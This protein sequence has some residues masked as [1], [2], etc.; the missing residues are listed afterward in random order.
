M[1]T[2]RDEMTASTV[3]MATKELWQHCKKK[4]AVVECMA[5]PFF[6]YM[7]FVDWFG[8]LEI[9]LGVVCSL[10]LICEVWILGK[11]KFCIH[12]L[13]Y[14]FTETQNFI[15]CLFFLF[16]LYIACCCYFFVFLFFPF[17]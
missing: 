10:K 6:I 14:F 12:F 13:F 1:T 2:E 7:F 16:F 17:F 15:D 5:T 11:V 9:S 3:D 8:R 4:I